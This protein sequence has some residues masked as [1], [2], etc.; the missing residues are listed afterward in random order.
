LRIHHTDELAEAVREHSLVRGGPII[1]YTTLLL[2][3]SDDDPFS[4]SFLSSDIT[5]GSQDDTF[6]VAIN[7]VGNRS[8]VHHYSP[9]L[10]ATLDHVGGLNTGSERIYAIISPDTQ[11]TLGTTPQNL[12]LEYQ[13][14]RYSHTGAFEGDLI[15]VLSCVRPEWNVLVF[16]GSMIEGIDMGQY[17]GTE[18]IGAL[19]ANQN[20]FIADTLARRMVACHDVRLPLPVSSLAVLIVVVVQGRDDPTTAGVFEDVLGI[21]KQVMTEYIPKRILSLCNGNDPE[22]RKD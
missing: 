22:G 21:M 7:T 8:G 11:F 20:T 5:D 3:N 17:S 4:P 10:P 18:I 6:V 13:R 1:P 16:P 19:L 15:L 12:F 9:S 2:V 14:L